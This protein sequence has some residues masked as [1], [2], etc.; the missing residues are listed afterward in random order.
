MTERR[1][2]EEEVRKILQLATRPEPAGSHPGDL[3]NG[4]TLSEIQSIAQEVGVPSDAISRAAAA[5]EA[6]GAAKRHT[7]WGMPI[8]VGRT[9]A[10]PRDLTDQE[11]D[12]LV[13]ELRATFGARGTVS[14]QGRL[15]AWSNG[16]LHASVE[17]IE[18]GYR[19]R[20]GSVK[21]DA[22]G[23][24][25]LGATGVAAGVIVLGATAL[26]GGAP[27]IAGSLALAL[28][29]GAAFLAN[30]LRLPRWAHEREQQMAHIEARV[31]AIIA[32]PAAQ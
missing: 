21:G 7:S 27:E 31:R 13:A 8:E 6:S 29:G 23:I 9:V 12:Q 16:N 3:S 30:L 5:L 20:L 4:L 25:A 26:S 15:K 32:D 19:L 1:Y 28:S 11:W 24:N 14:V 22:S 10:L 2:R 18:N 17:P